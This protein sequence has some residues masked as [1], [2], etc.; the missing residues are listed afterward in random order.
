MANIYRNARN[1]GFFALR[2]AE[3]TLSQDLRRAESAPTNIAYFIAPYDAI[4]DKLVIAS[5]TFFGDFEIQALSSSDLGVTYTNLIT[6]AQGLPNKAVVSMTAGT[7]VI[8][9]TGHGLSVDDQIQFYGSGTIGGGLTQ[10]TTYFVESTPSSDTFTVATT[11]GGSAVD[12][13]SDITG[14]MFL[15][16]HN[17]G[18]YIERPTTDI[19]VTEGDFIRLRYIHKGSP[20]LEPQAELLLEEL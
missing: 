18:K 8:T 12:I 1:I 20:I 2:N 7:D 17:G 10:R 5:A 13:T 14:D 6:T 19:E 9:V 11:Q 3:V 15:L 4:V 16:Y